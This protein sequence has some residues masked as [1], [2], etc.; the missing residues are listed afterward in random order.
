MK[1]ILNERKQAEEVIFSNQIYRNVNTT[2]D[3]LVKYWNNMGYDKN[4]ILSNLDK[5]L[6]SAHKNYNK[7]KWAHKLNGTVDYHMRNNF[8]LNNIEQV[9]ITEN[10]LNHIRGMD[11]IVIERLAFSLLVYAKILNQINPKNNNYVK[12]RM[13][14]VFKCAKI[15]GNTDRK[16]GY[17][18]QIRE[19]GGID[20][21]LRVNGTSIQVDFIDEDSEVIL[22]ITDFREFVL[23]YLR[24]RGENIGNCEVCGIRIKIVNNRVKYCDEC[25]K[26]KQRELWKLASQRYRNSQSS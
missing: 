21:P 18:H 25:W 26:G 1:I 10:E 5:F 15:I 16:Y 17:L 12:N 11:N 2:I 7:V 6:S 23:E 22:E 13:D 14:E 20:R 19:Y 3:L 9:N 4:T 8:D 24:W